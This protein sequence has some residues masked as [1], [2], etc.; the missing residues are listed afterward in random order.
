[1]GQVQACSRFGLVIFAVEKPH[2]YGFALAFRIFAD[3]GF[4]DGV[5]GHIT[6]RVCFEFLLKIVK[7]LTLTFV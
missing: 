4:D 6:A 7:Y 2:F 5:A 1:M 3:L